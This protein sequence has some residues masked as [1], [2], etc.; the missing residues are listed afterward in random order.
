MRYHLGFLYGL[1]LQDGLG[2]GVNGSLCPTGSACPQ[3][4][5]AKGFGALATSCLGVEWKANTTVPS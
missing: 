2:E 1:E 3:H 5:V 4:L